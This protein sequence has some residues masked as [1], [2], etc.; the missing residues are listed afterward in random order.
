MPRKRTDHDRDQRKAKQKL[1]KQKISLDH[2]PIGPRTVR[3]IKNLPAEAPRERR[4]VAARGARKRTGKEE[5]REIDLAREIGPASETEVA[6]DAGAP[7]ALVRDPGV[8]AESGTDLQ[9]RSES[10]TRQ[11]LEAT[12][13]AATASVV[14]AVR[15]ADAGMLA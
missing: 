14:I 3:R 5:K 8:I 7:R 13:G 9:L 4:V 12:A 1:L 2:G 11:E 10:L 6:T 15:T